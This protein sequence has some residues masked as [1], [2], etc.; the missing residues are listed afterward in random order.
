MTA[1]QEALPHLIPQPFNERLKTLLAH[2][3][4]T[5]WEGN[6]KGFWLKIS[7]SRKA[8]PGL[9]R[10]EIDISFLRRLENA[11]IALEI[12]PGYEDYLEPEEVQINQMIRMFHN[13]KLLAQNV[14]YLDDTVVNKMDLPFIDEDYLAKKRADMEDNMLIRELARLQ[15]EELI[16]K[17][18]EL[19][20][21]ISRKDPPEVIEQFAREFKKAVKDSGDPVINMKKLEAAKEA[22]LN[23]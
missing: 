20:D 9:S 4:N 1:L 22:Y 11:Q 7:E 14:Q 3:I 15:D 8:E 12:T 5:C 10:V 16:K 6:V 17:G 21:S 23:S 2:K 13:K 19:R 18:L